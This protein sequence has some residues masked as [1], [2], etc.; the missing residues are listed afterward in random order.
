[1]PAD[2]TYIN[3]MAV[4]QLP[5]DHSANILPYISLVV[6]PFH[7][8]PSSYPKRNE[9]FSS[10]GARSRE[11]AHVDQYLFTKSFESFLS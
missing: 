3:K 1:M 8:I 2:L 5:P 11:F 7:F 6:Q 4:M 9:C 10:N